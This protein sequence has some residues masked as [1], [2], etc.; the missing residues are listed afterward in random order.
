MKTHHRIIA[1]SV[2]LA[3][4]F[5]VADSI[6]DT[7]FFSESSFWDQIILYVSGYEL[8]IRLLAAALFITFGIVMAV[9]ISNKKQSTEKLRKQNSFLSNVLESLGHPFYVIDANDYSIK[10]ANSVASRGKALEN[11]TCYSLAHKSSSPC[12]SAEHP[13]PLEEMKKTRQPVEV[14]H[15]HNDEHGNPINVEVHGYPIFD[16]EGNI[17]QM[18]EYCLDA[19]ERYRAVKALRESEAKFRSLAEKSPNMIFI[20]QNGRIVYA[21]AKCE[22]VMLY[23][24]EEL[25]SAGFNFLNLIAPESRD[26]VMANFERHRAGE[27]IPPYEYTLLTRDGNRLDAIHTTALITYGGTSALLGVVTDV[28][29]RKRAEEG[30]KRAAGEWRVTFDSIPDMVSI[31][32]RDFKLRRVN[33]AFANAFKKEPRELIGKACYEVV[34]RTDAPVPDCPNRITFETGKTVTKEF[35]DPR[36]GIP[37]EVTTSPVFDEKGEVIASVHVARDITE[38]KHFQEQL[39]ITDRLASI[40][41]MA[42]GVAH[43]LNNPLT[44]VIG[45]SQ[46]LMEGDIPPEIKEDLSTIYN[47]AQ[48]AA[49]IVKNLLT[50][51]RKH[52]P[53]KQMTQVNRIAEEV[54]KWRAYEQRVNNIEV[55]K[56]FAG[57]LPEVMADH[58]QMQQVFLNIVINAESAMMESHKR[59]KLTVA[60][61]RVNGYIRASFIDDGPGIDKEDMGKIFDPFFTTKEVGKGTGLGLSICHGIVAE[62]GGRIYARSKPGEGA[63]FVVEL[64]L[65]GH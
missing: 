9:L 11:L 54:L 63:T 6:I 12:R 17:V 59:G 47:E 50:F 38:R 19:T 15:I 40:G 25:Y 22:E 55:T 32:D 21:N 34:H 45:F 58:F 1:L 8:Y 57:D 33:K 10:L 16:S 26:S 4:A 65:N 18:I 39:I 48:R 24:R 37:L 36:L 62:H 46:L 44:S 60:T 51:G 53:V 2:I 20:N 5:W 35:F 28:T 31:Q 61:E 13:C 7:I 3:M 27:D 41:E 43:E 56:Q 52:A 42:S 30:M 49:G 14:E 23:K 64:P 29:E